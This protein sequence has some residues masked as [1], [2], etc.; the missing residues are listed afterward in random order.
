MNEV[1]DDRF[2]PDFRVSVL[3]KIIALIQSY[4]YKYRKQKAKLAGKY[5]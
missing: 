4:M 2:A 3:R 5:M 1:Y